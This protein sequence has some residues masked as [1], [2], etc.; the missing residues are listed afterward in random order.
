MSI[1]TYQPVQLAEGT[2]EREALLV[3]YGV[4]L[5]A[6]LVRLSQE[7]HDGQGGVW[8]L[9][10]GFGACADKSPPLFR[11]PVDAEP[12]LTEQMSKMSRRTK[13]QAGPPNPLEDGLRL[14]HRTVH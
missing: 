5:L 10:A 3:F 11:N 14:P 1:F 13:G 6:V 9:L 4:D 2:P 8:F 12:W 7:K